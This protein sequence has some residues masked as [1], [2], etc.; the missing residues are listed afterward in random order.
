[1]AS[2]AGQRV[3]QPGTSL[4]LSASYLGAGG[5]TLYLQTQKIGEVFAVCVRVPVLG[6]PCL[7]Q[8]AVENEPDELHFHIKLLSLESWEPKAMSGLAPRM[9]NTSLVSEAVE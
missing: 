6:K 4:K 1:M 3:S 2:T 9:G 8:R 5:R 7:L